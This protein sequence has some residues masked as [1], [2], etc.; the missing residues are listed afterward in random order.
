M[1]DVFIWQNTLTIGRDGFIMPCKCLTF[2]LI[3][4]DIGILNFQ[5]LYETVEIPHNPCTDENLYKINFNID[6]TMII[7]RENELNDEKIKK[8]LLEIDHNFSVIISM[9]KIIK[10]ILRSYSEN[11][12]TTVNTEIMKNICKQLDLDF[13]RL[14]IHLNSSRCNK[15]EYMGFCKKYSKYLHP[16]L[17]NLENLLLM[18]STQ[19][20]FFYLFTVVDNIYTQPNSG[21]HVVA[22]DDYPNIGIVEKENAIEIVFKK[23]FKYYDINNEQTMNKFHTFMVLTIDLVQKKLI[24]GTKRYC[25]CDLGMLYWIKEN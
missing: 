25:E 21:V 15:S 19:A 18:L 16:V 12:I 11:E 2:E 20:S 13:P 24:L 5:Q 22:T 3:P 17:G 7:Y 8:Q 14:R 6:D 23:I 10:E 1:N 9:D 4:D